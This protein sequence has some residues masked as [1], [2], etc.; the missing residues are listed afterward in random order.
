MAKTTMTLEERIAAAEEKTKKLKSQLAAKNAKARAAQKKVERKQDTRRKVLVGAIILSRIGK[1]EPWP[2]DDLFTMLESEL[3]RD[4]DRALF[5]FDPIP[6]N[7]ESEN[8][9]ADK[10]MNISNL[11]S[12]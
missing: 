10:F 1:G 11:V 6:K 9:I 5:G 3:T 8:S 12:T 7:D 4:D 2:E